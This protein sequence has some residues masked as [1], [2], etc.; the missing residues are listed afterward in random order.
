MT[1]S[2]LVAFSVCRLLASAVRFSTVLPFV[3]PARAA[4]AAVKLEGRKFVVQGVKGNNFE[5]VNAV[6][7]TTG[8]VTECTIVNPATSWAPLGG[9]PGSPVRRVR[10]RPFA[11]EYER[12]VAYLGTLLDTE[13][14]K[15]YAGPVSSNSLSFSTRKD[16]ARKGMSCCRFPP[17]FVPSSNLR[18]WPVTNSNTHF[19]ASTPT[20]NVSGRKNNRS[21]GSAGIF[22]DHLTF[23]DDGMCWMLPFGV[24]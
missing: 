11:I 8:I 21:R 22:P 5:G 7:L 20:K 10:L 24:L 14:T 23:D 6:F 2:L 18:A 3:N 12:T 9:P 15:T 13:K 1:F 19:L 4:L 16:G 17:V